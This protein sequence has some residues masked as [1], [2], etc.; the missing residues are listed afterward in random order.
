[1]NL[2]YTVHAKSRMMERGISEADVEAVLS[3]PDSVDEG[4]DE[5]LIATRKISSK[6]VKIIYRF[7]GNN[8]IIITVC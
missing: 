4:R 6:R 3:R 7:E 8:T 2:I 5:A 1:M